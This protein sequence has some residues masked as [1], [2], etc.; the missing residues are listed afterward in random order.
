MKKLFL[1]ILIV[2]IPCLSMAFS[3]VDSS[4]I[5]TIKAV[6]SQISI[7][8]DNLIPNVDRRRI[9]KYLKQKDEEE[10][11]KNQDNNS[12]DEENDEDENNNPGLENEDQ[13]DDENNE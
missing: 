2:L 5:K 8:S 9:W 6:D 1:I 10:K 3:K 12:D 13:P 11:Q 4:L 7:T